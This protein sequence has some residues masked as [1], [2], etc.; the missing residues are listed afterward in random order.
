MLMR[1]FNAPLLWRG[2]GGEATTAL[3]SKQV[4][5]VL[6]MRRFDNPVRTGLSNLPVLSKPYALL[7]LPF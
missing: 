2:V 1:G 5:K 6:L 3:K 4:D 7:H